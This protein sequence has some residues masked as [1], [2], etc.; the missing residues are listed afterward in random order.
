VV[1]KQ[2]VVLDLKLQLYKLIW[3]K[4]DEGKNTF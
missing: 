2:L 3:L 1:G 4:S